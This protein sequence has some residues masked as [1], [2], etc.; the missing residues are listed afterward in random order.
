MDENA[1]HT[2]PKIS[3]RRKLIR[4]TFSVPAVLAVHNGSAL[5][6][7]SNNKACAIKSIAADPSTPPQPISGNTGDGFTRASY[8][9]DD[10]ATPGLWVRHSDLVTI[11]GSK[12]L[13]L[14]AAT[15]SNTGF[16]RVIT[17]GGYAFSTPGGNVSTN[18]SGSVALLFDNGGAAPNTVRIVGFIQ[19]SASAFATG[20]GVV[21]TSC[22]SSLKP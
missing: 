5:A 9:A 8:Y 2:E 6:A 19:P 3:A 17:G 15:G 22:W 1:Q 7:T 21:T 4:G 13:G 14:V 20:T 10:T 11:A 12:A 18:A 16:I